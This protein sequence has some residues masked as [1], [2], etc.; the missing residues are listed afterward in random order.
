MKDFKF[1]KFSIKQSKDVFRV[2]TDGVLLGALSN[3]KDA[4]S[5]LEV[6]TG[7]G[8][9]S[10][11]LAQRNLFAEILAIDIDDNAVQL[12]GENFEN[13]IF[14]DRLNV[15]KKDFKEFKH[16]KK[17]DLVISNPPYFEENHSKKD[18]L[19]RQM[20]EL[21]FSSLI[22]K[23]SQLVTEQGIFSVIIPFENLK[24]FDNQCLGNNFHLMRKINISGIQH[25]KV[26]RL[27]LEYSKTY[28]TPIEENFIIEDSP[29]K[30]SNQYLEA[31]KGFHVF[32]KD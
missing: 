32:G 27:I 17:F 4:Q 14:K 8:L 2:G 21:N 10:L 18:R 13:S 6:G 28:R 7:T 12:A 5:I 30:Y 31:T 23:A 24:E 16:E 22:K 19:A 9:I 26:K 11:M 20:V 3:V 25:S 15:I 1:Q 29:R